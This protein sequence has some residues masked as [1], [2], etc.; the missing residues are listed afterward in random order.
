[1][2][3]EFLV[4][5]K[6]GTDR[7]VFSRSEGFLDEVAIREIVAGRIALG[8]GV[9]EIDAAIIRIFIVEGLLVPVR[10]GPVSTDLAR[11]LRGEKIGETIAQYLAK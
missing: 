3:P 10:T 7:P 9:V 6:L 1:M 5:V 8:S 2:L 4:V 11:E